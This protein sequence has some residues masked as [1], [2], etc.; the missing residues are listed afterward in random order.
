MTCCPVASGTAGHE[1]QSPARVRARPDH[2]HGQL[3]PVKASPVKTRTYSP[4]LSM[5]VHPGPGPAIPVRLRFSQAARASLGQI[6]PGRVIRY[7]QSLSLLGQCQQR[8][9]RRWPTQT[10][11]R[12]VPPAQ[13]SQV[14]ARP[15]P[16]QGE[17]W[18]APSWTRVHQLWRE[19]ASDPIGV[20]F[21]LEKSQSQISFEGLLCSSRHLS[22]PIAD[23]SE[24][25]L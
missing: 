16:E 8:Q 7:G 10:N 21:S 24:G 22:L 19:P 23:S 20:K 6:K 25:L 9:A 12:Q 18:I 13:P 11:H 5:S 1:R 3:D 2:G 4:S 17:G 14:M 15:R